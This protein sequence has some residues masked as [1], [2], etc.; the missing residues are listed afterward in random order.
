MIVAEA[1][2]YRR[3]RV[4]AGTRPL[5]SL[6]INARGFGNDPMLSNAIRDADLGEDS[7]R[8]PTAKVFSLASSGVR[9]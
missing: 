7:L 9:R 8:I 2:R 6:Q 4:F 3:S 5:S 1:G